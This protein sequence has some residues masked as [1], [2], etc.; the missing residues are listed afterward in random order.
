MLGLAPTS[1]FFLRRISPLMDCWQMGKI[2][3]FMFALHRKKAEELSNRFHPYASWQECWIICIYEWHK[4]NQEKVLFIDLHRKVTPTFEK[5]QRGL[6][7]KRG[8]S[9]PSPSHLDPLTPREKILRHESS[10][11]SQTLSCTA[12]HAWTRHGLAT[13]MSGAYIFLY[14]T[15]CFSALR[16]YVDFISKPFR[17]VSLGFERG[18]G[19]KERGP[20]LLFNPLWDG[21]KGTRYHIAKRNKIYFFF[22][23]PPALLSCKETKQLYFMIGWVKEVRLGGGVEFEE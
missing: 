3:N 19:W 20:L 21:E 14:H 2:N 9:S 18:R 6:N 5:G 8:P 12:R 10:K 7:S 23:S 16:K 15:G 22:L 17:I 11:Q 1:C 4:Q 13:W